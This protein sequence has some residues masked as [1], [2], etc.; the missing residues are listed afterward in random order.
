MSK[1]LLFVDQ[2]GKNCLKSCCNSKINSKQKKKIHGN[3]VVT[4]MNN[5]RAN[6]KCYEYNKKKTETKPKTSIHMDDLDYLKEKYY[7]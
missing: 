3:V 4:A 6:Q 5:L 1:L 2:L 7:S